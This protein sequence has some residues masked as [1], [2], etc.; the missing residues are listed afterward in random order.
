MLYLLLL[1]AF[2]GCFENKDKADFIL[3]NDCSNFITLVLSNE[4]G[5]QIEIIN[6]RKQYHFPSNGILIVNSDYNAKPL[7]Y[8]FYKID[9]LGI[10]KEVGINYFHEADGRPYPGV[11]ILGASDSDTTNP[12]SYKSIHFK[13]LNSSKEKVNPNSTDYNSRSMTIENFLKD[14]ISNFKE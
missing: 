5:E 12:L 11:R 3:P 13:Y 10:K 1:I 2:I 6:G 4:C 9:Q 14:C 8:R 7:D